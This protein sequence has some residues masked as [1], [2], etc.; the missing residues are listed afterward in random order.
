MKIL[1]VDSWQE[2]VKE[3]LQSADK[4][5][6]ALLG[7][8]AS[9]KTDFSIQLAVYINT[10]FDA[11]WEKSEII[12]ADSRQLYRYMNIGTAKITDE[13][14][15]GITHHLI[16]VLDPNED[17][18]I[19]WYKD[20]AT[21]IIDD[22]HAR[23]VVPILVGG[24]MLYIS[25][26]VDGLDPLPPPDPAVRERLEKEWDV[27]DGW[28]L[29]DKLVSVDPDTAKNFQH[30]NK[31][32][33]V[34]AMELYEKTGVPPSQLKK[35]IPPPYQ[36]LQ[37]GMLWPREELTKR[38]DERTKKLLES[39][40]IEEVES[41]LDRG[42]TPRDPA[43]K[44]HGYKE[45]MQWLSSEEQDREQLAELISSKTR[46]YAKRQ[47]TWWGDDDRIVWLDAKQL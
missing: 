2:L 8:T 13:E 43:M 18:S 11:V 33:V 5:L 32:Y 21:T 28:T 7:P 39:G 44:S 14:K 40:W 15:R 45:I 25:A 31:R 38:I 16:D 37:I 29:Y 4:P 27:D 41:L 9:G 47:M 12:N 24:S 46:Q 35:T 23:G 10:G 34:R 42:Y 17:V 3:H 22:C 19:A 26:V 20:V 36:T 6:V 30:Q 1:P